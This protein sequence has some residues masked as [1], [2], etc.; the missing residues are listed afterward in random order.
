MNAR[1]IIGSSVLVLLGLLLIVSL[2]PS[3][4][5]ALIPD[6]VHKVKYIKP[7]NT[8]QYIFTT[9]EAYIYDTLPN[10][11]VAGWPKKSLKAGAVIIRSGAY[12][13]VNRTILNSPGPN[14]NCYKVS[15]AGLVLYITAPTIEN[16]IP[17]SRM[18][19][20]T[21]ATDSVVQYHAERVN[22]PADRPDRLVSLRYND[23]IQT[24]TR[25][26]AGSWSAR[27]KY[28]YNGEGHPGNPYNPNVTCNQNDPFTNTDPVYPN[29]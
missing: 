21:S 13:R 4:V 18:S 6:S 12:W 26:G 24:R 8:V 20:T 28:A 14:N 15:E 2:S 19:R 29:F 9:N 1:N 3:A 5:Q 27:I 25:D 7:D 10:E 23:V 17:N 22:Q 11:W 16:F